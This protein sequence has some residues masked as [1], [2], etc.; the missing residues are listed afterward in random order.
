MDLG[1]PDVPPRAGWEVA[2]VLILVKAYP[3]IGRKT[4]E[5]V[6][7]AGVRID[8]GEPEWVRLFPVG[9]RQLPADKQFHK[10][11]FVRLRVRPATGDRRPESYQPDLDSL[12]TG[13][14]VGTERAW[15]DRLELLEPISDTTTACALQRLAAVRGQNA[16]SLAMISPHHVRG[17][18]VED[19]PDYQPGAGVSLD[20]DLFGTEREVLE[21]TP[22]VVRYRYRCTES[23][24]RGHEQ[25]L[26]DWESGAFARRNVAQV[27][28]SAAKE[29]QRTRFLDELCGP[30]KH[31]R[32]FIGNQHQ[33]PG[34]F[35]VLGVFWPPKV[36]R[37]GS[38][39]TLP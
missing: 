32:F 2:T 29:R 6:C 35:L 22:F 16:P 23:T 11:Q 33:H 12:V 18:V 9:F 19:N 25:S 37:Q 3:A 5:S 30:D 28:V 1:L 13:R 17:L 15:G 20:V 34:S 8:R 39:F 4:G 27:G 36:A 26:V 21:A 24:C 7:V 31:T 38:L 14:T 10:Y